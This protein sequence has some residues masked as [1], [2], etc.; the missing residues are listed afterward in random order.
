MIILAFWGLTRSLRYT[1]PSIQTHIIQVL[2]Q[3]QLPFK[4]I[5]HTYSTSTY[6]NHR[7][8]EYNIDLPSEYHLLHPDEIIVDNQDTIREQLQL[9]RYRTHPDPWNT[10]YQ[11]VD[12]FILAMYS[13]LKVTQMISKYSPST[14]IFLRPDV[15]YLQPLPVITS[16]PISIP[17]FQL[18]SK[19][20]DRFAICTPQTYLIYGSI[21]NILY[22]YSLHYP[23]HSETCYAHYLKNVPIHYIDFVF[24]R[25]RA[26]GL[27]EPKDIP[28]LKKKM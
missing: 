18:H 16:H 9:E 24:C 7:T 4:I 13:K 25:I 2:T 19:F 14:V 27:I 17:S 11:T 22:K 23:L 26:S 8:K 1:H 5:M 21:F 12:N 15:M 6:T 28:L 20:N 10:N 3:R